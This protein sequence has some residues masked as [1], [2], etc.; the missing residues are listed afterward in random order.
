MDDR[1]FTKLTDYLKQIP[2]IEGSIGHGADDEGRWWVKF[3]I[4]IEHPLAWQTVQELGHVLNYLSVNERL[5][6]S[7]QPVSPPP[8]MNGGPDEFL[9]W[10]IESHDPEFR[11]GTCAK[12][13]EGRLPNPVSDLEQW[14]ME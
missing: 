9:S 2:A 12:W 8:Y 1:A 5:P 13:L 7:F 3:T 4:N 6:T 11:P 10:V 14:G